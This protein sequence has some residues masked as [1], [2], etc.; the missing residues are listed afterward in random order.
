MED[1]RNR[2]L[3]TERSEKPEMETKKKMKVE[4]MQTKIINVLFLSMLILCSIAHALNAGVPAKINFQG[5]LEESGQAVN[6]TRS[7]IFTIYAVETG[8]SPVWT[9]QP[10]NVLVTNGLFSVNLETGTVSNI[11]TDTFKGSRY[12]EVSVDGV[13]L[14]PR[15]EIISAPYSLVAQTLAD[16]GCSDNQVLKWDSTGAHWDCSDSVANSIGSG[17]YL[18]DV[19]VSSAIYADNAGSVSGLA[20]GDYLNDIR[21]SSAV[22]LDGNIN[23]TQISAGD[24]PG[25]V[26]AVAIKT[27]DYLNDIKVSSAIYADSASNFGGNISPTQITSG[28]LPATVYISSLSAGD[29]LN[30][31][32]VSSAIYADSVGN[33]SSL[34][35]GDYLNEVRVSSAVYLD[36]NIN[37]TQINA[38]DLPGNVNAVAIKTGDYLNDIKVSS[39]IYS[40]NAETKVAKSGDTMTGALKII[41]SSITVIA[42][43]TMPSSMW[44]STSAITPH[45]YVSTSGN[46]GIGIA[47]PNSRLQIDGPIATPVIVVSVDYS[48]TANDSIIIGDTNSGDIDVTL[49]SASGIK[50]RQYTIKNIGESVNVL[51]IYPEGLENIEGSNSSYDID[52]SNVIILVSDGTNWWILGDY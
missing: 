20:S 13:T 29:Y 40:D 10:N 15:Q 1:W 9:S 2:G 39:A 26:N 8:G 28:E 47:N 27:G 7:M 21:V 32:K 11:S 41:G 42:T 52:D 3:A 37:T 6:D 35:S 19:K 36:G 4:K 31:I 24:L 34:A 25:N 50:G 5:R 33:V 17:E 16:N 45:L 30:D 18:N 51:H 14:L 12:I 43:D 49:P 46:T 23:T 48:I 38:G 22:Y 44:I